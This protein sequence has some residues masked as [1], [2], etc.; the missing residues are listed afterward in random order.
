MATKIQ[1]KDTHAEAAPL[2]VQI[3]GAHYKTRAI[4]PIE[5]CHKNRLGPC[6]SAVVKYVTRWQDKGGIQDL[7]KAIHYLQLLKQL[8]QEDLDAAQ[9]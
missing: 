1:K 4:Q 7:D 9:I 6:E 5:Y 2:D 8:H 3:G